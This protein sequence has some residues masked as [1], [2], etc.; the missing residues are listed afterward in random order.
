MTAMRRGE[1]P[2]FDDPTRHARWCPR[3]SPFE[4]ALSSQTTRPAAA[5]KGATGVANATTVLESLRCV[6]LRLIARI[7]SCRRSPCYMPFFRTFQ[8]IPRQL[9]LH[10]LRT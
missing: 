3:D 6:T 1:I 4:L 7:A 9:L 8:G 2:S 5:A 10:T